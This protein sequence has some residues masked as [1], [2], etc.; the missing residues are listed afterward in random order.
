MLFSKV[1]DGEWTA[2]EQ[3]PVTAGY[4]AYEPHLTPDDTRLY[5]A[6]GRPVPEGQPGAPAEGG[7]YVVKRT[8]TG[9]SRPHYAGQGMF[10]S[11]S[12]DGRMYTTDMSSRSSDG[13]T[14][15]AEIQLKRGL[16]AGYKRL[17]IKAGWGSQAH[18]AIA[19]DGSYLLF[20]VQ[21]G[22]YLYVSF[23]RADGT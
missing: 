8:E 20:D 17:P 13:K 2:P 14:Y 1:L 3:L 18:P 15:L 7:Y 6:W 5:F 22:N 16:F 10:L 23:R 9:W 4:D 12:R 11:S 19:P 21:E